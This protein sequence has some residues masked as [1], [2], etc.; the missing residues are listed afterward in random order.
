MKRKAIEAVTM[1]ERKLKPT[2]ADY[3]AFTQILDVKGEK[4]LILDL[5]DTRKITKVQKLMPEKRYVTDTKDYET[6]TPDNTN[7][8]GKSGLERDWYCMPSLHFPP[9]EETAIYELLPVAQW[10]D[11]AEK[12]LEENERNIKREKADKKREYHQNSIDKQMKLVKE[13]PAGAKK[14][15]IKL[16]KTDH[17]IF[18]ETLT[19]KKAAGVCSSCS[20]EI[21]YDRE[22]EKPQHNE[23]CRCPVCKKRGIYKAKGKQNNVSLE[24]KAIVMQKTE[25]G[26]VSRHFE[27]NYEANETGE[28]IKAFEAARSL[29]DGKCVRD[30]YSYVSH[31]Y[32]D[33]IRWT[34]SNRNGTM[35]GT[36]YVYTKNLDEVLDGT[37]Y[38]YCA[39]AE[40]QKNIDGPI[41]HTRLLE[42]FETHP[43]IEYMIKMHLYRLTNEYLENPYGAGLDYNQTRP[44]KLLKLPKE[45]I[46]E[47]IRINGGITA[48][49]RLRVECTMKR[50]FTAEEAG[51]IDRY[52]VNVGS[53]LEIEEYTGMTK[54]LRY[55]K[56]QL[57]QKKESGYF[58]NDWKDY[59]RM[60][61]ASGLQLT[62]A[63]MFPRNLKEEHDKMLKAINTMKD[64]EKNE[65]Y[66]EIARQ[67][68]KRYSFSNK[69]LVVV[70]PESLEDIVKEGNEQHHCVASYVNRVAA[71]ETCILF[72]RQEEA[73]EK[74][75]YTMEIQ[76]VTIIQ[77]RG[78][79][80]EN[81][82]P[83]VK[84]FLSKF[85]K[86]IEKRKE[87]SIRIPA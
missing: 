56:I 29:Y 74:P 55:L 67:Y 5:Y 10:G 83:E 1:L 34:D 73:P 77:C 13:L 71:G 24:K 18:Y 64:I 52:R 31:Y 15:M 2:K 14:W 84:A 17:F 27:L 62:T 79:Y 69:G 39:M 63:N 20:A 59:I 70:I 23:P 45:K 68:I 76:D 12:R 57:G 46:N 32:S 19:K 47:L 28:C 49:H 9:G 16:F 82:T 6:Y 21:E 37:P 26:F 3:T 75:F 87:L 85:R 38:K 43:F 51:I 78:K 66:Q 65:K 42:L 25:K 81:Q 60:Q 44:D 36:G 35:V 58:I 8:W 30:Y 22:Q 72:V 86:E 61:Q 48:L 33:D 11:S 7:S 53:L 4:T 50:S 80:N 54:F 40:L 41:R